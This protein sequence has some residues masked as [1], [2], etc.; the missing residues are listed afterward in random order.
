MNYHDYDDPKPLDVKQ[1]KDLTPPDL[2]PID[3][4]T[5]EVPKPPPPEVDTGGFW[6]RVSVWWNILTKGAE[7]E[8]NELNKGSSP[9]LIPA[10]VAVVTGNWKQIGIGLAVVAILIIA[11]IIFSK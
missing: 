7:W 3:I 2:R 4:H 9:K 8:L 11:L 5:V 6:F 1:P 10:I